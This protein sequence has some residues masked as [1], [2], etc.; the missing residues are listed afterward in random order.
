MEKEQKVPDFTGREEEVLQEI[1]E[2]RLKII[3]EIEKAVVGQKKVI[4]LLLVALLSEGHCVLHGLPGLGKTL[5]IHTLSRV[6]DLKFNRIQFT[7]D[8]MP[9]DII[10]TEILQDTPSG[11]KELKFLEG[12]VFANIILADE[13]N[14]T[15][16]KTQAALLEAMQE[17]SVTVFGKTYKLDFPF[18]VLATEN[19]IEQEGTYSLPES[20]LDRFLF[21]IEIEYP[22]VDEEVYIASKKSFFNIENINKI[23]GKDELFEYQHFIENI[24][25]SQK[26][27]E[28]AVNIVKHTRPEAT[29]LKIVKNNVSYGAG[30]RASQSIVIASKSHA[31]LFGNYAVTKENIHAVI[32]SILQHRIILNY[33][34]HAEGITEN[35]IIDEII[36]YVN[37]I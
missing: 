15:P 23:I 8:L 34:A 3:S 12:P 32:K 26:I 6:L 13:I 25:I 21:N 18:F 19:P 7:P 10:G 28:Y 16:P 11:A 35:K 2:S 22:D 17:R 20:Q 24:P 9:S 30:V 1:S 36:E 27:I 29:D 31:A 33:S 14:R 37:S 4:D 5:M